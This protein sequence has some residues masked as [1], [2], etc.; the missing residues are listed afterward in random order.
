MRIEAYNQVQQLYGAKKTSKTVKAQNISASDQIQ[1][2]S[3]GKDYQTAKAAVNSASD[4][5]EDLVAPIRTAI[6]NGTYNVS[7]ESFA[8]K[9]MQKYEEISSL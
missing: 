6:Q 2:S 3:I 1:I 5:R 8:E 9:L 7:G 4:I